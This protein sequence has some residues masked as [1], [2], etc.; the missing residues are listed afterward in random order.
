MWG[1]TELSKGYLPSLDSSDGAAVGLA[2][3]GCRT[4]SAVEL[5]VSAVTMGLALP[6]HRP[7][8]TAPVEGAARTTTAPS[9]V[10][11][12]P[13]EMRAWETAAGLPFCATQHLSVQKLDTETTEG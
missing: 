13:C 9:A 4:V 2:V 11:V 10:F 5:H 1:L 6:L 7:P 3:E 12:N 8:S